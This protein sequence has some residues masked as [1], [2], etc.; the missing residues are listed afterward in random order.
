MVAKAV[1]PA[2]N[3]TQSKTQQVRALARVAAYG[4]PAESTAV[5]DINGIAKS[6]RLMAVNLTLFLLYPCPLVMTKG[7][8]VITMRRSC[9][10]FVLSRAQT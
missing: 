5:A 1:T 9:L 6:V 2:Q 4:V 10:Q 3:S 7:N 8:L